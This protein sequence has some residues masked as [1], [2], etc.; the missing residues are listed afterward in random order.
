MDG[1]GDISALWTPTATCLFDYYQVWSQCASQSFRSLLYYVFASNSTAI[2]VLAF[3]INHA[4]QE[5]FISGLPL[6]FMFGVFLLTKPFP[7]PRVVRCLAY[8]SVFCLFFRKTFRLATAG[9]VIYQKNYNLTQVPSE[10]CFQE[11]DISQSDVYRSLS[12]SKWIYFSAASI[13]DIFVI[14]VLQLHV[15][16][17]RTRG[18]DRHIDKYAVSSFHQF[19][20]M[21]DPSP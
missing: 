3:V 18:L 4:I 15:S 19:F 9:Y 20:V 7:G 17:M 11:A 21:F 16:I 14:V 6:V 2:Y 8:Y 1:K 5:D 10:L 13:S 12:N